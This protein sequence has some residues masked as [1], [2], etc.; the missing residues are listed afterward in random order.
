MGAA[1]LNKATELERSRILDYCMAEPNINIFIIGDIEIYGFESDFQDVWIQTIDGKTTG[2]ILRYHD[3][4]IVYSKDL[5]MVYEEVISL[6]HG[7][8]VGVIS[9][10]Q[11]V[12]E[13]LVTLLGS[14]FSKKEMTF[15]ELK[16][17]GGSFG[18]SEGVEI[19]TLEEAFEIAEVYGKITEFDGLYAREQ[20]L[21]Y[22]Q[23][24]NRIKSGEG[25]HMIIREAGKII[26][27]GNTAAETSVSAMIGGILT[28]P[29][30]RRRGYG[31][32]I[33]S[34]L[35]HYL[36]EKQK[37]ICLFFDTPEAGLFFQQLGFEQTDHWILLRRI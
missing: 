33:V 32:S 2:I 30:L 17:P 23:I 20:E 34:A 14:G 35:C 3:N 36:S 29:E 28:L 21:R 11:S 27:H 1:M 6:M 31:S 13:P 16:T 12:I 26:S 9:G 22:H 15:C 8:N 4:F 5:D 25:T 37:S 19:A 24:A 18:K 10:K 7:A